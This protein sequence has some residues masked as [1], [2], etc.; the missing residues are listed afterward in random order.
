MHMYMYIRPQATPTFSKRGCLR[1]QL[2]SYLHEF[3]YHLIVVNNIIV[4][5][6]LLSIILSLDLS[7]N[8]CGGDISG[9]TC[10]FQ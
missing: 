8:Y 1:M 10:N 6:I 5:E 9:R 2:R 3:T 7:Y 4:N